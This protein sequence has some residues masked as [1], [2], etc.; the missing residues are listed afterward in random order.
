MSLDQ[1]GSGR[2]VYIQTNLGDTLP[3]TVGDFAIC[4]WFY[5]DATTWSQ[6]CLFY[7]PNYSISTDFGVRSWDS[8]SSY[9]NFGIDANYGSNKSSRFVMS[10]GVWTFVGVSVNS[11]SAKLYKAEEGESA[12]TTVGTVSIST[13]APERLNIMSAEG[14]QWF[15]GRTSYC[16]MFNDGLSDA[17]MLAEFYYTSAVND[18]DCIGDWPMD[19]GSTAAA[20]IDDSSASNDLR[21]ASSISYSSAQ[22]S[23]NFWPKIQTAIIA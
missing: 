3:T 17:E 6:T 22:A 18:T 23:P 19:G 14:G 10:T 11:G 4:G 9:L 12:L 7:L 8:S 2:R 16:R 5:C 1:V 13:F 21:L 20:V 15:D